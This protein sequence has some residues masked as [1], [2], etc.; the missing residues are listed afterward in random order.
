M[1]MVV[2]SACLHAS[3]NLLAKRVPGGAEATWAYAVVGAVVLTPV[4]LAALAAGEVLP[5]PLGW[6]FLAGSAALHVGYFATLHRGYRSGD[7]SLVYPLARGSGPALATVVAMMALG[8]RPTAASLAGTA[9]VAVSAFGLAG[10]GAAAPRAVRLGLLTGA[11]IAAYTVW[12]AAAV[13][14]IGVAPLLYAWL[15]EAIRAV[16]L[17]PLAVRR[18]AGLAAA[19]RASGA[20]IV[21]VGVLSPLAYLVIL[22][23]FR[24]APVS[25][26]APMREV[27]ILI[28]V[29]LGTGLLGEGDV[30]RR[31]AAAA[32]MLA[33]VALLATSRPV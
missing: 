22:Y 33:G 11:F 3:W 18:R 10:G 32:G 28:T 16:L 12:D 29:A 19:W 4:S 8:E 9:L 21:G 5:S 17:T 23:A 31:L 30:R 25:L 26:V 14:R 27:S 6:L 20:S 15:S 7:L 1:A 13:S 24:L 2:G